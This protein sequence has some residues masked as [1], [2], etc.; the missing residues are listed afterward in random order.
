[1]VLQPKKNAKAIRKFTLKMLNKI[2]QLR[3]FST[4]RKKERVELLLMVQKMHL[5][6]NKLQTSLI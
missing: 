4:C 6:E 5:K 1:M 2:D 3:V